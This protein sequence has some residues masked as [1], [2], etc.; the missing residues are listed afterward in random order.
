MAKANPFSP[1]RAEVKLEEEGSVA[2]IEIFEYIDEWWGFGAIDL[3]ERLRDLSAVNRIKL[4]IHSKGGSALEGFAIYSLLTMHPAEVEAEIIGL[5]A[6]AASVIAMA[7]D[8]IK[9]SEVA[10]MMIHD[11]WTFADGNATVLRR[12]AEL[13]DQTHPQIVKAY[14]RHAKMSADEITAAMA[15]GE[16]AGTWYTAEQAVEA[17]LAHEIITGVPVPQNRISFKGMDGVPQNALKLF[18]PEQPAPDG[19]AD[20]LPLDELLD[21]LRSGVRE[22]VNRDQSEADTERLV[23]LLEDLVE[24]SQDDH[25]E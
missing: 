3:A 19:D 12:V 15:V 21:T 13:L 4:R 20:P 11:P 22:P 9:M 1:L 10:F 25:P 2:V 8:R 7:A 24:E 5:A 14:M 23:A 18:A 17:G 6:S 16:G